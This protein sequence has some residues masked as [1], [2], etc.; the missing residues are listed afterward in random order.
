[1]RVTIY[2]FIG[3]GLG[4]LLRHLLSHT[5]NGRAIDVWLQGIPLGT[6]SA[7][8]I[9]S[10]LLG[11]IVGALPTSTPLKSGLTTG[12]MG[13]LTT[14]STLSLESARLLESGQSLRALLHL[15]LH[16]SGGILLAIAGLS[17]GLT[18]G[19]KT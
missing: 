13:G 3:G 16:L 17:L 6:L 2:I 1:M 4:A 14:F 18:L 19:R 12:L 9:G 8:L 5:L 15:T 7:N 11:F 10:F